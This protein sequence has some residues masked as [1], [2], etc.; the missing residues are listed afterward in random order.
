MM[1]RISK[2]HFIAM[3]FL[4]AP[5][6]F[7]YPHVHIKNRTSET[8]SGK[9]HYM[10]TCSDDEFYDIAPY[11]QWEA[12]SRGLCLVTEIEV[13]HED[14]NGHEIH[15]ISYESSGTGY[16]QFQIVKNQ[17]GQLTVNRP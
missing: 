8:V 7:A 9:V 13:H 4:C 15:G 17:Y 12:T 3:I 1:K 11:G 10:P 5:Q 16:A 6:V 14:A 2:N